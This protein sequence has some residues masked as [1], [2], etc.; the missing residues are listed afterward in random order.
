M[1]FSAT[2]PQ[3]DIITTGSNLLVQFYNSPIVLIIKILVAVYVA[4]LIIDV[5]LL[6]ILRD[7]PAHFRTGMRGMDIPVV[8]KSKMQKRWEKIKARLSSDNESQFKVAIIEADT[9]VD[10]ILSGIGY[11]G[12]NMSERFDN[13]GEHHLDGHYETLKN[14]HAVR[15]RIVHEADFSIDHKTAQGVLSMY[16]DFLKYL[17]YLD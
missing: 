16:E 1:N 14:A 6:L 15:N 11:Q 3:E 12:K 4:I 10:E 8:S 13:I 2:T 5:V 7:V 9:L 17:E